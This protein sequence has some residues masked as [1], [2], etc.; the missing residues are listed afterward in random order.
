MSGAAIG[1]GVQRL[2]RGWV[3]W[4]MTTAAVLTLLLAWHAA[5]AFVPTQDVSRRLGLLARYLESSRLV[6][7]GASGF[8]AMTS[9]PVTGDDGAWPLAAMWLVGWAFL[10]GGIIEHYAAQRR[11]SVRAFFGACTAYFGRLV[12]LEMVALLI[13]VAPLTM[14]LRTVNELPGRIT[15]AVLAAAV[16]IVFDA[17]RVRLVIENRISVSCALVAGWRFVRRLPGPVLLVWAFCSALVA[18]TAAAAQ[19]ALP[20]AVAHAAGIACVCLF[21]ACWASLFQRALAWPGYF[22]RQYGIGL[23]TARP[24]YPTPNASGAAGK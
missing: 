10:S 1:D 21:Y 12:R 8:A 20:A 7:S 13:G 15:V 9:P 19:G 6:A 16:S 5:G 4:V 23:T 3:V 17:A 22:A 14:A 2:L 18:G 24:D 11:T